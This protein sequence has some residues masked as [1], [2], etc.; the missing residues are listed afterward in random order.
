MPG[1]VNEELQRVQAAVSNIEWT[2]ALN[3]ISTR[4]MAELFAYSVPP[5][6]IIHVFQVVLEVT[7]AHIGRDRPDF[8]SAVITLYK[9]NCAGFL[10]TLKDVDACELS[11]DQ[12]TAIREASQSPW[13]STINRVSSA[14]SYMC[15]WMLGLLHTADCA[16]TD[17]D[18][19]SAMRRL[20]ALRKTKAKIDDACQY[21]A[22]HPYVSQ[23][24]RKYA[25]RKKHSSI[26]VPTAG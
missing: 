8:W 12:I 15:Q 11:I 4:D 23:D 24:T 17:V 10:K 7:G 20:K 2:Q 6:A 25:N 18:F 14:A 19:S 1:R 5:A 22:K 26:Q 3:R 16:T 9:G 21:V 13:F